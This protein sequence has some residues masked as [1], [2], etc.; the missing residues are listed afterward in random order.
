MRIANNETETTAIEI[1][2]RMLED[3]RENNI[4]ISNFTDFLKT[5][6]DED[7]RENYKFEIERAT[8]ENTEIEAKMRNAGLSLENSDDEG[9]VAIKLN[10]C[11]KCGEIRTKNHSGC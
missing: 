7:S 4:L 5:E 9:G 2:V 3:Y 1:V 6:T 8:V 11:K 10:I